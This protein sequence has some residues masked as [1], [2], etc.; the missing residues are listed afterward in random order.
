[1]N[2]QQKIPGAVRQMLVDKIKQKQI[3]DFYDYNYFAFPHVFSTTAGPAGGIG[4]AALTRFTVHAY[5]L[6]NGFTLYTCEGCYVL[7]QEE[8]NTTLKINSF[9]E[10]DWKK[11]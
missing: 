2:F 9:S 10:S 7:K 11:I 1:M 8:F 3:P 6:S 5:E 4:E